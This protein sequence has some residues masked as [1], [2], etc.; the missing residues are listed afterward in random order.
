M[1]KTKS[2]PVTK[3][4]DKASGHP[5]ESNRDP[6]SGIIITATNTKARQLQENAVMHTI[7]LSFK[8]DEALLFMSVS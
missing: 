1:G 8:P 5:I 4:A 2:N 6:K 7:P 3:V